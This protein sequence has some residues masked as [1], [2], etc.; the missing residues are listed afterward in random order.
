MVEMTQLRIVGQYLYYCFFQ[1]FF[2]LAAFGGGSFAWLLFNTFVNKIGCDVLGLKFET[3]DI[4]MPFT[5]ITAPI[6]KIIILTTIFTK[7]QYFQA[8]Y[9]Q[10]C[11]EKEHIS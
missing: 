7:C 6:I 9:N 1:W 3:N 8:Q 5:V 11:I 2:E 4:P 10:I